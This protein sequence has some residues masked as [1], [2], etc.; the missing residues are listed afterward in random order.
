MRLLM[1]PLL[2]TLT[3]VLGSLVA[4]GP[5]QAQPTSLNL[6]ASGQDVDSSTVAPNT[7]VTT[8]SVS[9]SDSLGGTAGW[10][11]QMASPSQAAITNPQVSVES[12]DPASVSRRSADVPA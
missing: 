9:A 5:A 10:V 7:T 8:Q 1:V 11:F 2:M 3:L 6:Q 12:G 4:S